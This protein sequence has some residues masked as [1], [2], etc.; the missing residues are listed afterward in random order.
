MKKIKTDKAS[1]KVGFLC[2]FVL[3]MPFASVS[4]TVVINEIMYHAVSDLDEHD[5]IELYNTEAVTVNLENWQINGIGFTFGAGAS[6]GPNAY[7]ILAKD[8]AQFQATYGVTANYVYPGNLQNSG[9]TLQVLDANSSV[10]DEVD[11]ADYPPWPIIPDGIGPSLERI[12][13]T[14]NGDTPR[15]WRASIDVDGHTAKAINSVK[16]TGLPPWITN[17]QHS[18]VLPDSPITVT[19][20]VEDAT[21]VNLEYVINFG[22][23]VVIAMLDDG[24]SGD[25]AA[26]DGVY[27]A[28]IPAQPLI[29]LVRYRIDTSGATG[30]MGFPRD[31]DTV[32]YTGY[33]V[34]DDTSIITGVPVI[35]WFINPIDY[36]DALTHVWTDETE[37][38]LVYYNGTLY[39]GVQIRVRGDSS[40]GWFKKNWKFYFSH[41]HDFYAPGLTEIPVDQFNMQSFYA[42]KSFMRELLSYQTLGDFGSPSSYFFHTCLYQNGQFFGLY[43]YFEHPDDDYFTRFGLDVET[44]SMYEGMD[45]ALSDCRYFPIAQLPSYYEKHRPH[46]TDYNDL[47]DFLYNL[48]YLTGQDRRN[49]IFDNIDVPRMLNFWAVTVAIH[50]NDAI[51]KNYYLYRDNAGTQRWYMLPWDKDLTWGRTYQ[52]AVLNDEIWADID[53][54]SGRA[55]VSPGHPLYGNQAHQK[56]DYLWNKLIDALFDETDV[57]QMYLR[58]LRT[59]MDEGLQEPNTPYANRKLEKQI[60][61]MAGFLDTEAAMDT[62]EWFS[63]GQYQ[64]IGQAAQL[65]KDNYLTVRRTHFFQTHCVDFN[66]NG[67]IP[68]K[69]TAQPPIVINEIMYNPLGGENDEFLE[70]YN[71]SSTE[72]VDLTD[73]RLDGVALTFSPGTVLLPQSYLVVVKNDV[74]F[75]ATYGS[76]IF[77]AAQYKGNLDNVGE[78]LTLKDRQGN[79]IDQVL[80]DDQAP[81]P[82][83]PDT[84]GYSL[85]LIDASKDNNHRMNWVAGASP[86]GTPGIINSMAGTSPFVPDLWVNEVLPINT[87]INTDEMSEYEPWI[88]IYNASA[89]SI[90]LG[91]MF[92]TDDYNNPSKWAI[93]SGTTLN[94]GQWLLIWADAEPGDGPLHTNFSLNST[95]GV[96]ALYTA[97]GGLVDYL[98][99]GALATD[100]SYG[101]Y[102][103]GSDLL[104]EFVTPTP[105]AENYLILC[106]VIL[107]EY[108]AVADNKY[109][110]D[111]GSDTFWGR[112]LGNGGD[113]FELVVTQDHLDMRGWQLVISDDTGGAGQTIQTLTLTNNDL[114]SDLRA[115]TIIT[116]SENLPDDINNYDP[117][118]GYWWINVQ[119]KTGASGTYINPASFKVTNNNWQLT[120]KDSISAVVFGPAGEGIKPIA[121][122]G[123]D[124][125]FKLEEDPGQ[126]ITAL[127][128]YNDGTSSTFGAPNIYAAGTLVQDFSSL[129]NIPDGGTPIPDPLV[130]ATVPTTT[131]SN[132]IT[133][134][135]TA[136][137]DPAGVEYYFNNVTDP[138][139]DSGWQNG[140]YYKDKELT[141]DTIYSYRA[142]ARD[143]SPAQNETGWSATATAI[144]PLLLAPPTSGTVTT[145]LSSAARTT[146][147]FSHT[148]A[149]GNN[150]LLVVCVMIRGGE[151]VN[152]VTYAGIGLKKA[153]HSGT[154]SNGNNGC[155][156]E[157]WYLVAPPVGTANVIVSFATSVDPSGITAVNFTGVNQ[158][159]PIGSISAAYATSGTNITTNITT[160]DP[161]SLIFGAATAYGGDTDPFTPGSGI[162]EMW[163]SATGTSLT[164]DNGIWGGKRTT[165]TPGVYTFNTTAYVSDDW[166]IAAIEIKTAVGTSPAGQASS[167]IP[168]NGTTDVDTSTDLN[169]TAGSGATLHDVYFDTVNP[170]TFRASQTST[171][172]DTG[173]MNIDT[174]YYWRIDEKNASGATT[175]GTLWSFTT[176]PGL[177]PRSLTTSADT[178]GTV[179][180]PGIGT[181]WYTNGDYASIIASANTNYHFTNWTGSAVTAGR[182]ADPNAFSTTVLMDANYAVQAN[183]GIDQY[184]ITASAG[185]N[186]SIDPSGMFSK[187]YGSN[188]LFTA[189]PTTGYDVNTWYVDG[190][191]VQAGGTMYT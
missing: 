64:T 140:S 175:K 179:T 77:V 71:P 110:K 61:E 170:P 112:I 126:F 24:L 171:T 16:A 143:K 51:G 28:T 132:S 27:G 58:R 11:Y 141:P 130:W 163:D 40:R 80:F 45:G 63:W 146:A 26:G 93:P 38:S 86:G 138:T 14:L 12:D 22:T 124:E 75:R 92:L 134:I 102:F 114:W 41:G 154:P 82:T 142:K 7:I 62:S 87:S 9:E 47:N 160:R 137:Y 165:T 4:A 35:H 120:I 32:S 172:F 151:S 115:G 85:E 37:P 34:E 50:D 99:Y 144:T 104:R 56:Y 189:T 70:L 100:V 159:S 46:D 89:D 8:A 49:F 36:A 18:T 101:R 149:T 182:V 73:W 74:Q 136:A 90:D 2:L 162:T 33:V 15:N 88:E 185:D 53:Y 30:A 98:N 119:A 96:A 67:E 91:G 113:W 128:N 155:R 42:D 39:D 43:G 122:I 84:D 167:P 166:A 118:N 152:S 60:D 5:F 186:G 59:V 139:H 20:F 79:I 178:N 133:M 81:W 169:W 25:G 156:I 109:I 97:G 6:I 44:G 191:P 150:R 187:D 145:N 131:S 129:R 125:V 176:V 54:I 13:P 10:I 188:Q 107:N 29:T 65:L 78:K 17:V 69:Q 153:I 173:I 116:V 111:G 95:G 168:A 103:D 157:Q 48:N 127:A 68:S 161:N 121:A 108:S 66:V 94:G 52:G 23:P 106:P 123:N 19:A 31:D 72:S 177:V 147:T 57:R 181:Y 184:T 183:F 158:S 21:T 135:T 3:A 83:L 164:S 55:N 1:V 76:G 174:V 190:S 148:V 117:E 105:A 180:T